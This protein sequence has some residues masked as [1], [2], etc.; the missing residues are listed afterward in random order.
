MSFHFRPRDL[1]RNLSFISVQFIIIFIDNIEYLNL[2]ESI[3]QLNHRLNPWKLKCLTDIIKIV[4]NTKNDNIK[5]PLKAQ[6]FFT[7]IF[8]VYLRPLSDCALFGNKRSLITIT[9]CFDYNFHKIIVW[10]VTI[11]TNSNRHGTYEQMST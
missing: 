3:L 6:F 10:K 7:N 8:S 2:L 11:E 4:C 1:Q 9:N 5:F